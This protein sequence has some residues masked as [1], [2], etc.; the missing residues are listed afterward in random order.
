MQ[1]RNRLLQCYLSGFHCVISSMPCWCPL[2][3][4]K[5]TR[6]L[7][8]TPSMIFRVVLKIIFEMVLFLPSIWKIKWSKHCFC[9]TVRELVWENVSRDLEAFSG[10]SLR[11]FVHC[12]SCICN[13]SL[14]C[15]SLT[16][17]AIIGPNPANTYTKV[18]LLV[19]SLIDHTQQNHSHEQICMLVF[20]GSGALWDKLEFSWD[21]CF[22]KE[23]L[24]YI[25]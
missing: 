4:I 1:K 13:S 17:C 5:V 14:I 20:V 6:K 11:H 21:M 9:D 25:V 10:I 24:V 18:T 16:F 7:Q 2:S 23:I 12:G 22:K 3:N 15:C 8:R 19:N